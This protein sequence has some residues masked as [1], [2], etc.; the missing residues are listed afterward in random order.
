MV[1]FLSMPKSKEVL[2]ST[3]G[4]D[5]E[6]D[7]ETKVGSLVLLYIDSLHFKVVLWWH[8]TFIVLN[9]TI[10]HRPRGRRQAKW[11][12]LLKNRRA[13]RAPSQV[14]PLRV[15]IMLVT[16]CFRFR[17]S[18]LTHSHAQIV[19]VLRINMLCG[20]GGKKVWNVLCRSCDLCKAVDMTEK[21][22]ERIYPLFQCIYSFQN[23]FQNNS[24]LWLS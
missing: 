6:S 11:R 23:R 20:A 10:S 1:V 22:L 15:I 12:N 4:S 19:S 3:S 21:V 14:A 2:S 24:A 17:P 9:V 16:T 7:A 8:F 18:F 5:S 13:E